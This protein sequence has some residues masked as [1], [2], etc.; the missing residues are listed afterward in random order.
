MGG[1]MSR[2]KGARG[3]RE[4][5][6]M[7]QPVVNEVYEAHDLDPPQLKRNTLQSDGGGCDIAGL[8][9]AAIEVKWHETLKVPAWWAQ[10]LEQA[11]ADKVPVLMYRQNAL[12]WQVMMWGQLGAE[13]GSARTMPVTVR[14]RYFL[15]WFRERLVR[16]VR[17]QIGLGLL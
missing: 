6:Q 15:D 3:E 16:E 10:T 14:A 12:H 2:D 17:R 9:W 5:I 7:L 1:R 8:Q 11:G 4:V 13:R